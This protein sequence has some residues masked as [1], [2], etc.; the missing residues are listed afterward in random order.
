M[1]TRVHV[2]KTIRVSL[3]ETTPIKWI[4]WVLLGSCWDT[5]LMA[6]SSSRRASQESTEARKVVQNAIVTVLDK[7]EFLTS[8]TR[9]ITVQ[10]LGKHLLQV[11]ENSPAFNHF[12]AYLVGTLRKKFQTVSK[13]RSSATKREHLWRAFHE[14]SVE[15]LSSKWKELYSTLGVLDLAE[16]LFHQTVNLVVYEQLLKEHFA[17]EPPPNGTVEVQLSKDE[18]NALRYA[19]GYV[20]RKLLKRYEKKGERERKKMGKKIDQFEMCLGN[21]AIASDETDFTQSTSEWFHLV[22]RG[23]LFPINDE[24][25]MFFVAVEKITRVQLPQQHSPD[26]HSTI[27]QSV[28]KA[29]LEDVDVQFHWTLISQ[30]IDEED[31]AIELLTEISDMWVTIRGFAMASAWL[32]E[33]KKVKKTKVAKKKGLRKDL[34]RKANPVA[35][36]EGQSQKHAHEHNETEDNDTDEE[37]VQED[38]DIEDN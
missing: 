14:L 7:Q 33:Y 15:Q 37:E 30:D 35:Q 28:M 1:A 8:T 34:Y 24:T 21:M 18:L 2:W 26:N 25:L 29:I 3:Q 36:A 22:N 38:V 16:S 31:D 23:G 12:C 20:P 10:N 4:A 5:D 32:E 11:P 9:A 27:K 6:S 17:V 19:S 13:F